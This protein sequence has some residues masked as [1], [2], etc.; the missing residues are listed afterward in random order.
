MRIDHVKCQFLICEAGKNFN[1][2]AAQDLIGTHAIG[3]ITMGNILPLF[4]TSSIQ[5]LQNP[6]ANDRVGVDAADDYD[7]FSRYCWFLNS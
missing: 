5:I 3:S 1:D 2:S 7:Y 6:F 4:L